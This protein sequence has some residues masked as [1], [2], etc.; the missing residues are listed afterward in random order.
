MITS[1]TY[2]YC[3]DYTLSVPPQF[4][5]AEFVLRF[6]TSHFSNKSLPNRIFAYVTKVLNTCI[7]HFLCF[8]ICISSTLSTFWWLIISQPLPL[9][10]DLFR[11]LPGLL[12]LRIPQIRLY[13]NCFACLLSTHLAQGQQ[14]IMAQ[15]QQMIR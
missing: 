2:R 1:V 8:S 10:R 14:M 7:L 13:K 15:G 3:G 5:L 6:L 12:K 4:H 9:S 11:R